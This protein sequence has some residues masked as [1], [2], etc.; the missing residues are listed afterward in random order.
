MSFTPEQLY[1]SIQKELPDF[2]MTYEV[3]HLRQ[4]IADSWPDK[5]DDSAARAEWGW[6]PEYTMES[7]TKEMIEQLRKEGSH[8]T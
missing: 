3:D 8:V 4:E 6:Q 2:S 1:A 7:M 5:M